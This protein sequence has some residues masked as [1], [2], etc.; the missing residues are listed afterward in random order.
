VFPFAV[1]FRG[2][3]FWPWFALFVGFVLFNVYLVRRQLR[4]ST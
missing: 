1:G 4:D 3:G 2:F